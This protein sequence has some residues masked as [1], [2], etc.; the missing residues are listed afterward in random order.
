MVRQVMNMSLP[1]GLSAFLMLRMAAT[2]LLKNI[3]PKR[4][5]QKSY[6]A[7]KE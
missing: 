4:E 5:K 1:P 7:W 3:M 6:S 2:G